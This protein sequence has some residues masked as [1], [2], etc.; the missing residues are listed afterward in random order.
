MA[1][2]VFNEWYGELS[3]AQQA[4]YRKH[5]VSPSDHDELVELYGSGAHQTITQ[6]VKEV[7]AKHGQFSTFYLY[8]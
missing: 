4:A 6:V 1:K 2:M 8:R 7:A 3:Y 5:N